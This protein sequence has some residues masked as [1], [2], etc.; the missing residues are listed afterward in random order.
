MPQARSPL[1][2]KGADKTLKDLKVAKASEAQ[3]AMIRAFRSRRR[4]RCS[5][6][7]K[8]RPT[9]APLRPR[10]GSSSG[11][12]FLPGRFVL[13][14]RRLGARDRAS[15]PRRSSRSRCSMAPGAFKRRTRRVRLPDGSMR[16]A[17]PDGRTPCRSGKLHVPVVRCAR[18]A[19]IEL[20]DRSRDSICSGGMRLVYTVE[21]EEAIRD[22]RDHFADEMRQE[23]ATSAR[24][25]TRATASLSHDETA[26]SSTPR[27]TSR[28]P[29][30]RAHPGAVHRP[31]RHGQARRPVP[32]EVRHRAQLRDARGRARTR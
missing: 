8:G 20:R 31:G 13:G 22:K 3:E 2:A 21:V 29:E 30:T 16:R 5:S 27:S 9:L 6:S 17:L 10:C 28:T 14:H 12:L 7:K 1:A 11:F 15:E 26:R 24:R 25:A 23:L 18:R 32:E 4:N 19:A